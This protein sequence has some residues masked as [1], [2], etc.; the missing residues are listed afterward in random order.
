MIKDLADLHHPISESF[1]LP[2]TPEEWEKYK[3]SEEQVSNF[4]E[5]GYLSGIKLLEEDQVDQLNK[6]LEEISDPDHPGHHLFYEFHS[7][8]SKDPNGVLFHSLGHWRIAKG[9]H[10]VLWNPL[11]LMAASQMLENKSIRF[12]HDQL[13]CKPAKHGGVVAW[14]QDYSYWTRTVAMQH[15]TCW[16]ALDDATTEN[17]CIHYVPKSHKWGLLDKPELAGDMEGLFH[18]LSD[19][20][21]DEFNPIPIELKKG[22]A[23]FHHPLMVHGSFKNNSS[24]SRRAFVLNVFV[25]G[26]LSNTNE[27]LLNGVPPI[28]KGGKIEGKFFPLLFEKKG[29]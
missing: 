14:H 29:F 8:E 24:Y 20:Q 19:E 25:D 26:T 2:H 27:E 3:L 12:W 7:N 15:L 5:Y 4:H 21:K 9:F 23:T 1:I 17:G 10:D 6:E 22:Y 18:Y 28:P 16:V 13:F 11:F